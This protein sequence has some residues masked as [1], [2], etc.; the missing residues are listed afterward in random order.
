VLEREGMG[1]KLRYC[2][3]KGRHGCAPC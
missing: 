3:G 1:Q 2:V